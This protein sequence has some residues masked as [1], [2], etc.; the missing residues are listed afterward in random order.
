[1]SSILKETTTTEDSVS[2]RL[3]VE[4]RKCVTAEFNYLRPCPAG[5]V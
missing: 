1:M 5:G 4:A 3:A 2:L